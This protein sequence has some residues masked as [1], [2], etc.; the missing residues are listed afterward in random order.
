LSSPPTQSIN[1]TSPTPQRFDG[2]TV[3][4]LSVNVSIGNTIKSHISNFESQTGAKIN[5]IR[6]PVNNLYNTLLK[7]WS[8]AIPKYDATV[9][10]SQWGA[11][12]ANAGYI[13][14]L[15]QRVQADAVLKWQDI[16]P[17]FQDF[18]ATYQGRTY[19]IPL[20]GDFHMAYYRQDL[21]EQAKL[22][23]PTTWEEYLAIAKRFHGQDLNGDGQPDYG[24]CINI[25]DRPAKQ[26][27]AAVFFWSIVSPFLQSQ[28]TAQ[29]AFFDP[30]TMKPLVNNQAFVKALD[31]A[32]QLSDYNYPPSI[33]A[34]TDSDLLF[35]QGRC[36][37]AI[38]WGD[39]GTMAIAPAISKVIDKVGATITPGTTQIL[40]RKT[41]K[42]VGCNKFT[43]PYSIEGVNHAPYAASGGWSGFVNAKANLK[44]K[45]AAY[46]FLSFL[47]QPAQS[48]VDVTK[49]GTGFSPYRISQFNNQEAWIEAG[50]TSGAASKYLG[51]ISVSLNNPNMVLDLRIP[52]NNR[53]QIEVLGSAITDFLTDKITREEAM[54]RIEKGWEKITNQVGRDSQRAAYRAS[55]GL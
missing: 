11:D 8:S 44:V 9:A 23:P 15:S 31:I 14:D 25:V 43:C 27:T 3:N 28:G 21:L 17:F 40:D 35:V 24:S 39:I 34:E 12:F 32:K 29:G 5:L 19:A 54:Q 26:K 36:A 48:N 20:D 46:A 4:L 50:M 52:Q 30:E 6:I 47:S 51:G 2:I 49:G 42:L 41:G 45:N 33:S 1:T 13:Q 16:S 22:E 18:N 55:L 10:I 37:L 7:D 53:Y 38:A